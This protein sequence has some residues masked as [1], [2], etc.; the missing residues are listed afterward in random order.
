MEAADKN[1]A[2]PLTMPP[3]DRPS[4]NEHGATYLGPG[5]KKTNQPNGREQMEAHPTARRDI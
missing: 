4:H 3:Q 5:K 1:L 2:R